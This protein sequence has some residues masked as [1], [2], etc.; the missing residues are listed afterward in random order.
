MNTSLQENY[1]IELFKR[2]L[3]YKLSIIIL[4]ILFMVAMKYYL[5]FIPSTYESYAIIK[6]NINENKVDTQDIL[7]DSLFKTNTVGINQEMAILQTYQTNRQALNRVSFKVQYFIKEKY[8]RIEL[9]K[10][11]PIRIDAISNINIKFL[12][13][14]IKLIPVENGFILKVKDSEDLKVYP[15]DKMVKTPYFS[16]VVY[17]KKAFDYPIEIKLNGGNRHIY[18]TIVKNSLL[19]SQ[20]KL[21]TNLIKVAF[22]DTIPERANNYID[23]L[24][25]VY[26]N[27]SIKKKNSI[28]SKIL[29]FLNDRLEYTR[30][31]LEISENEL[32]KYQSKNK[33]IDPSIKSKDSV[34]RLSDV[35]IALSE[36]QLKEQLIKNLK[37]FLKHNRNLSAIAPTLIEFKDEA[38]L[39]LITDIQT[40][41][42]KEDEL[43][44]DFTDKYP[45]LIQLRKRIKVLRNQVGMNIQSLHTTLMSKQK[46]LMVRK[47]KYEKLLTQLPNKEK[48]LIHFRRNYEVNSKIYTYLLEQKS[49]NELV[50]VATLSDYE[51]VD[52]AYNSYIPIKPKRMGLLI[53]AGIMGGALGIFLAFLRSF[54]SNKIH[55]EEEISEVTRLPFYGRIPLFKE[56]Q[57]LPVGIVEAYH[58]LAVNLQFSK[59]EKEGN[60]VLV[61]SFGREEGKTTTVAHL[62]S[63][64]AKTQ[65][66]SIV[67]DLDMLKP[68]LHQYFNM[69]LSYSGLSTYLSRQDNLGNIIFT[70]NYPNIDIILAGPKPP[71]PLE[72]LQRPQLEELFIILKERYDYIFIDAPALSDL[73]ELVDVMKLV[74]KNLVVIR[75]NFSTKASVIKLNKIIEDEKLKNTGVIFK[76]STSN[77]RLKFLHRSKVIEVMNTPKMLT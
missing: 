17:H 57:P 39:K 14:L 3:P 27:R 61:T 71:D 20:L 8:K 30:K 32:E 54:F 12:H 62:S 52:R 2:V 24:V 10:D 29:D 36:I 13:K 66:N 34:A 69:D 59:K 19:V 18:E 48:N 70:T 50:K 60:I 23:A 35:E 22:Q 25:N 45:P 16:G 38:T 6:V 1:I 56:N 7:R 28:N 11:I 55:K 42:I 53:L 26:I 47:N 64:F 31:K 67:V 15:Y 4:S 41:Q 5:Y 44:L 33:S 72:L 73:P 68:S 49:E 65:C 77:E 46:N 76:F 43:V 75:E 58:Q 74:D 40:L 9:Y 51:A 21:D 37:L 63:I